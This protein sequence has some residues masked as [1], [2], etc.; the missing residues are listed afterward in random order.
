MVGDPRLI[1]PDHFGMRMMMPAT[2][3]ASASVDASSMRPLASRSQKNG[4]A[5]LPSLKVWEI[6]NGAL[7]G[8]KS[9][10]ILAIISDVTNIVVGA[11]HAEFP[12]S[13]VRFCTIAAFVACRI[14]AV[15]D[16]R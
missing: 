1:H 2:P 9:T 14:G 5:L 3:D 7:R 16:V 6:S 12:A 10:A 15:M 4:P 13:F 8:G 11:D